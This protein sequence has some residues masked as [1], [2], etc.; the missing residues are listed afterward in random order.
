[1][2]CPI[3]SRWRCDK[4]LKE[5]EGIAP[6]DLLCETCSQKHF[7]RPANVSVLKDAHALINGPRAH[8]YGNVR[9][10]YTRVVGLFEI[11]TGHALTAEQGVVFMRCVKL[12]REHNGRHKR[13]NVV[14]DVG[15]ADLY[16]LMK[17][18]IL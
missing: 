12:D 6:D 10:H 2:A 17:E 18:K 15:Y 13:D 16:N 9:E 1:M 7:G 5:Y 4:C 11:L 3:S 8:D 14:D